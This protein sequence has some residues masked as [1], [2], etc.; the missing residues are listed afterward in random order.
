MR[1]IEVLDKQTIDQI[2][3]GE[4]V[5]RPASVIKELTENAIDAGAT[6]VTIEIRDGGTTFM[7]ITDNG[8]GIPA[9]QIKKAFLRHAT[10]KIRK[11]ED[12]VN[13]ASLGF[14]GE[15]LSSIS[16]VAQVECITK[17]PEALTGVRY[18]IEGGVEKEYEEIGAPGGTTFII[19]NLFFNTPARAK[20]L[21]SP[22]TEG[23]HVS[24][25]V[26]EL[27]LSHP[28][29]SF[30]YIQNGQNKLYTSGNGNLKE[31]VYQIFGRDLT[32]ELVAVDQQT[33]LMHVHGFI[34][35]PNVARGNRAFENYFINGRYVKNKVIAKAI[36]DAYHGFLMQHKY[37]FTLLYLDIVSEKV[38]VNVHPQKLEVRIS[39]QEGVYHQLCLT[40]QN[41]LMNRERIP[42]V[43]VGRENPEAARRKERE[44]LSRMNRGV[45][46]P[47]E[48]N[49][50]SALA[51]S[52]GRGDASVSGAGSAAGAI[53]SSPLDA[54]QKRGEGTE[55]RS[56]PSSPLDAL[57]RRGVETENRSIPSSPLDALPRRGVETE[58]RAILASPLD[59]LPGRNE[60]SGADL[61]PEI[62]GSPLDLLPKRTE[63]ATDVSLAQ[64]GIVDEPS[65]VSEDRS[66]DS[67]VTGGGSLS[68][69]SA[70]TGSSGS[71]SADSAATGSGEALS[72]DSR[73]T[74]NGGSIYLDSR[75]TGSKET[76]YTDSGAT[77]SCELRESSASYTGNEGPETSGSKESSGEDSLREAGNP[78]GK[79]SGRKPEQ[80]NLFE[81]DKVL[82]EQARQMFRLIGQVFDTYW[83]IEYRDA[84]YIIDQHAAHEKVNYERMMKDYREKT[85]HSQMLYPSIVLDLSRRE[86]QLLES[87]LKA[88]EDL[89]FEVESF[90]GNSFKINAVPAN[91]YSVASD[92][93]F[94][95]ILAELESLGEISP[96][97]I[98]EKLA[99][100]SCKAAVKGNNTLS[101]PE[102]NALIDEL[103][104]LENPY[105]CP[106]G[107]PTI[108][109]MT[110]YE[111]DKKFKRIV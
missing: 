98:P 109:S 26:E 17:T 13:I 99:S 77:G 5:E 66:A 58:N 3:A 68:V 54:L 45:P 49:H 81:E 20:F 82:S 43:P 37:P 83:L 76:I 95:Q 32:R 92:E 35:N 47:F 74:G 53:P 63:A 11:A 71:L 48:G 85:I 30:K 105:N 10:S 59:A 55:N 27:A 40:I 104:T 88:F 72:A 78:A 106:H 107:R 65:A 42:E 91:L 22:V 101:V 96:K 46:E 4:V 102:A 44:R 70:A 61:I 39:D 34:G 25:F 80:L 89:G 87:N 21:K 16:A 60:G 108:V 6:A 110:R 28:E 38:D 62:P 2:A 97:L 69:D 93:L 94:M 67:R 36:E 33:E 73:A 41:A 111:M 79:V 19:R 24:S 8:A 12:L 14:R 15:A 1:S 52:S 23:N 18:C 100:M 103:L 51:A 9:D 50:R 90:G 57:P 75:A 64:S 86:A 29:I 56:I 7:R 84:L 31:I